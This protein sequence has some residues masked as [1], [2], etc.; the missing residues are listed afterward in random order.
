MVSGRGYHTPGVG[1]CVPV[2]DQICDAGRRCPHG[3]E[4]RNACHHPEEDLVGLWRACGLG[5]WVD[6]SQFKNNYFT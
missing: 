4:D 6:G 5:L 1:D 2:E 3:H